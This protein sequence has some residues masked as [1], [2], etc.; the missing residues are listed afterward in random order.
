MRFGLRSKSVEDVNKVETS[1]ITSRRIIF[2]PDVE[3]KDELK[4]TSVVIICYDRSA[5]RRVTL[6]LARKRPEGRADVGCK[7]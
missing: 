4:N 2:T 6:A 1:L 7:M 5:S 3:L